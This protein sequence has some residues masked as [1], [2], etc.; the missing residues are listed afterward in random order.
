MIT[1]AKLGAITLAL[2]LGFSTSNSFSQT[3]E[4]YDQNLK[5]KSRVA[6]DQIKILGESVRISAVDSEVKLLSREYKPYLNLKAESIF[7]YDQP[8]I[9]TQG[10]DG[11]GAFHEYGEEILP[12]EYDKVQ[13]FF[14]RLLANKGNMYWIY[15]HSSRETKALGTFNEA[16]LA[17]NGQVIAKTAQGYLLPLSEDPDHLYEELREVNQNYLFAKEATG[18][19]LINR[20]G[21]YVLRPVIDHLVHLEEDYF[22]AYDGNQYMLIKGREGK[23]DINYTSYHKITLED[24][25]MLEFIHGKLRRVMKNDGILLDQVGMEKV[26][27]VG[28]KHYNVFLRD[29]TVGLLGQKGWEIKPILG[30]DKI[31]P[32]KEGLF[33]AFKDGKLGY[34]DVLGKWAIPAQYEDGKKFNEGFAA[35][36]SGNLWGYIDRSGNWIAEPQFAFASEFRRGLAV[37]KK[38]GKDNI[39]NKNGSLI[40]ETGYQRISLAADNYFITE[41]ENK[42]GLVAPDGKEIVEPKFQELR[43]EDLNKILVRVGDKYGLL[44]ENGDYLLPLYYRNIMF[45]PGANQILAE[46]F[47]QFAEEEAEENVG[48]SKKKRGG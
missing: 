28:E 16:R 3:Y 32:G 27:S 8:W 43:R 13:T 47:Y 29:Q 38:S 17:T 21:N 48:N 20:E 33:P 10:K 18:Y 44:D 5:L 7:A 45:D 19:G 39:I 25:L 15:D 24:G 34:I 12:A 41:E 4:V 37:V 40:L 6:Y 14:T 9:V 11:M 1:N 2:L 46:D 35:V 36:K 30:V 26:T 31:L 42:F 23:A 22:Y